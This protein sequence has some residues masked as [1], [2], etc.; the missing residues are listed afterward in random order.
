MQPAPGEPSQPSGPT[1]APGSPTGRADAATMSQNIGNL[2]SSLRTALSA[3]DGNAGRLTLTVSQP[4]AQ[5]ADTTTP[6]AAAA[7]AEAQPLLSGSGGS[8]VV[9]PAAAAA[10]A[11]EAGLAGLGSGDLPALQAAPAAV[12]EEGGVAAAAEQHRL[13]GLHS[14]VDLRAVALALER[15]LPYATLLLFLFVSSHLVGLAIF[16]FL[17]YVLSRLNAVVRAQVALKQGRR[18]GPLLGVA[19]VAALQVLLSLAALHRQDMAGNLVLAGRARPSRFWEVIF[20]V[21]VC[22]TLLRYLAVLLKVCVL[23]AMPVDSSARFRRRGQVFTA[24]EYS[25]ALYRQLPPAPL[26]YHFFSSAAGSSFMATGLSGAYLLVKAQQFFERAALAALA[27]QQ[28]AVRGYGG[29]PTAEELQEAGNTCP[30]CQEAFR[31]PL[32]LSC[33]HVFCADC[34]GEWFERE[35]TCPMC[36]AAVGPA[37]KKFKSKSDGSTPLF[38]TIF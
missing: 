32:R 8:G 21:A 4:P 29:N 19:G 37:N 5:P 15:G 14:S 24:V 20:A 12:P 11:A 17:T 23:L 18:A 36:R 26:W 22:D 10:A 38:P 35:R 28:V 2:I 7:A 16:G 3:S 34:C 30:I 27:V 6:R 33:G 1:T 25:C 9:Q 31:A 13:A